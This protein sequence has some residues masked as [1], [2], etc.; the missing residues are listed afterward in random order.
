MTKD[1]PLQTEV[2]IHDADTGITFRN[3]RHAAEFFKVT[4]HTILA[5]ANKRIKNP[6]KPFKLN[7]IVPCRKKE[8]SPS[9][10]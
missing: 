4:R 1:L 2:P 7:F 3:A 10:G 9:G 6:T 5:Y 8:K